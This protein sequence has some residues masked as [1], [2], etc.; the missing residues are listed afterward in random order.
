MIAAA[1]VTPAAAACMTP[2]VTSAALPATHTPAAVVSPVASAPDLVADAERVLSDGDA[3][4]VQRRVPRLEP[5]RDDQGTPGDDLPGSQ[6]HPAEAV[7]G[8]LDAGDLALDHADATGGQ[9]LHLVAGRPGRGM[10]E[11]GHVRAPLAPHQRLRGGLRAGGQDRQRRVPQLPAEAERA[12]HDVPSPA[13]G[14]PGDVGYSSTRPV[15]TSTRRA[16]RLVPSA[17]V[18]AKPPPGSRAREVTVPAMIVPP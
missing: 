1:A 4:A 2:A 18:T 11:Q 10:R 7:A 15:A 9:L 13:L 8:D 3:E 5:G 6:A 16:R 12:V 17:S 14:Q